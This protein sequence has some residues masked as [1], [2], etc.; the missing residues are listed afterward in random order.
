MKKMS[1]IQA[2]SN[3]IEQRITRMVEKSIRIQSAKAEVPVHGS[4]PTAAEL[5]E[6]INNFA[7]KTATIA[8]GFS[9]IPGPLG[10]LALV[11]ELQSVLQTQIDLIAYLSLR[12]H[13]RE[14]VTTELV[15]AMLATA[16]GNVGLSVVASQG[17]KI[18]LKRVSS[19]TVKRIG[20]RIAQKGSYHFLA[21]WI[22]LAGSGLMYAHT[23]RTTKKL[24][25]RALYLLDKG[26]IIETETA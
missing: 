17:G 1:R 16:I 4:K 21:K 23:F 12:L 13:K 26:I 19:M 5:E 2:V 9:L 6:V 8:A 25:S 22:P 24:G 15:T 18:L 7:R 14:E 10:V 20:S 3:N 11:K